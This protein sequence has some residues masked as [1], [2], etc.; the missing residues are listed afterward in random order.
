MHYDW[1]LLEHSTYSN[2]KNAVSW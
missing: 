1:A 2:F